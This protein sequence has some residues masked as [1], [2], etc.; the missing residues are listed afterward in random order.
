MTHSATDILATEEVAARAARLLAEPGGEIRSDLGLSLRV[1]TLIRWLAIIGQTAAVGVAVGWMKLNLP[2]PPIMLAIASSI[3]VNLYAHAQLSESPHLSDRSATAYLAFDTLQLTT[4][5]SLTGGLTNPFVVLILAPL[6]VA[7]AVLRRVHVGI[8]VAVTVLGVAALGIFD[9]PLDWSGEGDILFPPLYRVGLWASLSFAALF[10]GGY[11]W[12]VAAETRRTAAALATTQLALAREQKVS[13]VGALAAA[14]AHELG[15]PLGTITVVAGELARDV[16]SDSPL[17]EDIELLRSQSARCR[18]ILADLSRQRVLAQQEDPLSRLAQVPLSQLIEEAAAPHQLPDK[19]LQIIALSEGAEPRLPHQP[20]LLHG[21]GNLVQNA[22]Q[23]ATREVMV[24]LV[25]DESSLNVTI[26]DDGPGF[27]PALLARLGEPYL[28]A[29]DDDRPVS[30]GLGVFIA[31]TLLGRTGAK[32]T[33]A[34]RR[35]GGAEVA[36]VW[37]QNYFT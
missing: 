2:L 27:A 24:E 3:T 23:F 4:L 37:G 30:H 13:A 1:Q 9:K 17:R 22:L 12:R 25:W 26:V 19:R 11:V 14:L 29:R 21:L 8:L 7:A 20:E 36:I 5:L 31:K 28:S 16:P 34:N 33:F 18:D 32:L 35:K 15:T 10:I 6:T